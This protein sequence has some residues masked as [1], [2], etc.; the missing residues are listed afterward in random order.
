MLK[1]QYVVLFILLNMVLLTA[2]DQKEFGS[3]LTLSETTKISTILQDPETYVGKKVQVE[4]RIV[5]VCKKRGCWMELASDKE[6]QT[7]IIKVN[8]GEIVFPMEAKGHLG[9]VEGTVEK[10]EISRAQRIKNLKHQAEEAGRE[11]DPASVTEGKVIYR[12][13]GLGARIDLSK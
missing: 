2:A 8:D 11:F 12:L 3:K 13:R 5:D 9:L 6:F 4:G 10:L 1:L 7:I